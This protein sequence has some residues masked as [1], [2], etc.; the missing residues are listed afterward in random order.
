MKH[1][2]LFE[3]LNQRIAINFEQYE[4]LHKKALKNAIQLNPKGF[5]LT[6]IEL[7]KPTLTGARFYTYL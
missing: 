5:K 6:H 7:E 4:A 1:W 2:N 3:N